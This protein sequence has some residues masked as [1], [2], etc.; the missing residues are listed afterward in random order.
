LTDFCFLLSDNPENGG[1]T[2]T[3]HRMQ[4]RSQVSKILLLKL[5]AI[6]IAAHKLAA[7]NTLMGSELHGS[8]SLRNE[9]AHE[10]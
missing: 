5:C 7:C 1:V 9:I 4:G 3:H 6:S 8:D 2:L 10:K